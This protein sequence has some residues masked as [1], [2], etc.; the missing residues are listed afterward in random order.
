[1]SP[2]MHAVVCEVTDRIRRRS[3]DTRASYLRRIEAAASVADDAMIAR[4][5]P[6]RGL[7]S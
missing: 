6:G 4:S 5:L 7:S 1:M 2:S 3:R